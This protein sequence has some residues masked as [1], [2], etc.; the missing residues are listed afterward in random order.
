MRSLYFPPP[1]LKSRL[2]VCV[3]VLKVSIWGVSGGGKLVVFVL[4]SIKLTLK[5][6]FC[7]SGILCIGLAFPESLD[8]E[9]AAG[10]IEM[11]RHSPV[12]ECLRGRDSMFLIFSLRQEK[13][14]DQGRMVKM[15]THFS[16][17]H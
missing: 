8:K 13:V 14:D 16:L 5:G 4:A 12:R 9:L 6:F 15:W 17:E 10:K 3:S 7:P 2:I 11:E 1:P